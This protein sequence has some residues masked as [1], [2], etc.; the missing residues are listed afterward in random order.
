MLERRVR[1]MNALLVLGI[2]P[3]VVPHVA[4]AVFALDCLG[5]PE[6]LS[7]IEHH[8]SQLIFYIKE[9]LRPCRF[10]L[11]RSELQLLCYR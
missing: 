11:I 5:I 8:R 2:A 7:L 6:L 10:N 3:A 1:Y 4:A 9:L